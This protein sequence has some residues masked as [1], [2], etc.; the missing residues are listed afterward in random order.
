MNDQRKVIFDQRVEFM[1]DETVAET[2]ADMRHTVVEDLVR[3]HVPENAYPEQWDTAGLKEELAR[4]LSLDLPVDEWAK[5]E[6]I[7]D[8]EL[9]TRVERRADEHMASKVAQWGSDV[10]RYVEKSILLQSLDHLWREHLVTLE[11][12]RQ[13]IGLRGYGQRDPLNEYKSEAFNLFE[14]MASNMREAVTSQLMRVEI[15]QSPPPAEATEL[16]FMQAHHIDPSTGEDELA[17]ADAPLVPA[18]AGNGASRAPQRN[19]SD[20]ASWGKVGRN[21]ACPCG[22]GKK[23]K[24]CHGRY[25]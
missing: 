12:L 22:S 25:A 10:I 7:A 5:E 1:E 6:G 13:V 11:H 8:E 2:V 20:P 16:P 17:M 15:V 14:A 3:K 24:H 21:E 4:V 23:Y 19:P 9:I 18:M